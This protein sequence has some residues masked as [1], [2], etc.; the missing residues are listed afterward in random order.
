MASGESVGERSVVERVWVEKS[1]RRI[2]SVTVRAN[3][4]AARSRAAT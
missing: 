2:F 3:R 4:P 1:W